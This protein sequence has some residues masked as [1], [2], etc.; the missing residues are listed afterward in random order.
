[1]TG[2]LAHLLPLTLACALVRAEQ[3]AYEEQVITP[4][5]RWA[6]PHAVGRVRAVFFTN[7]LAAREPDELAQ[8]FDIEAFVVPVTGNPYVNRSDESFMAEALRA[9]A[10][11]VVVASRNTWQELGPKAQAQLW[12]KAQD[13]VPIIFYSRLPAG[14]PPTVGKGKLPQPQAIDLKLLTRSA[15]SCTALR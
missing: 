3:H 11:V 7:N 6:K 5:W 1:M 4:H 13:G 10:D 14:F 15:S 2:K 9:G 12:R 8:R